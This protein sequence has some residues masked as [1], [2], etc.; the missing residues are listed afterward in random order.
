MVTLQLC[1]VL[2]QDFTNRTIRQINEVNCCLVLM[3]KEISISFFSRDESTD[4]SKLLNESKFHLSSNGIK[5]FAEI[6][7]RSLV[8]VN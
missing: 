5:V 3:C 4:T 8:K 1:L 2:F 6:F 7:F